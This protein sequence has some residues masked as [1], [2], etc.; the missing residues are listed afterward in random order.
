MSLAALAR[1][2]LYNR[3]RVALSLLATCELAR[4]FICVVNDL[5]AFKDPQAFDAEISLHKSRALADECAALEH[6][7]LIS[8]CD[9]YKKQLKTVERKN[10]H[11]KAE[12]VD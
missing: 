6:L 1:I 10:T 5:V 12:H 8:P 4:S 7:N 9:S 2:V 11:G 3:V